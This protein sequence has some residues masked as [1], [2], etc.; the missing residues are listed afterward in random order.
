M[1]KLTLIPFALAVAGCTTSLSVSGIAGLN[2]KV[3]YQDGMP[4]VVSVKTHGVSVGPSS[5]EITAADRT[6]FVVAIQNRGSAPFDVGP[7]NITAWVEGA[8]GDPLHVY[9]YDELLA[10]EKSRQMWQAVILGTAAASNSIN[11]RAAGKSTTSGRFVST[12]GSGTYSETTYDAG[13]AFAAQ[14]LA[15]AQNSANIANFKAQSAAS[16]AALE[17]NI[18]KRQTIMPGQWHGGRVMIDTPEAPEDQA[19]VMVIQFIVGGEQ[20]ELKFEMTEN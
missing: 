19:L 8:R 13:K 1:N 4:I 5:R 17:N 3:Q 16:L 20:H 12:F 7:D 10:E 2:Q 18:I 6:E 11:A 14:S 9:S 15:N